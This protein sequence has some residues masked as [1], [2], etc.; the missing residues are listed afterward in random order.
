VS[1]P[2]LEARGVERVFRAGARPLRIVLDGLSLAAGEIALMQAPSGT[3]KS[4][5]MAMLGLV[6]QPDR[7]GTLVLARDAG[8]RLDAAEGWQERAER[9]LGAARASLVGFVMQTGA[10][11]PF[12]TLRDN[13]LEPLRL[14]RRASPG[15]LEALAGALGIDDV[16]DRRPS[17]VSIGQRQRA[18]LARALIGRPALLLADEPTAA[19]DPETAAAVDRLILQAARAQGVAALIASHRP[20]GALAG[21]ARRVGHRIERRADELRSVF[22]A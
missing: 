10:L 1:P 16:L 11:I 20:A 7:I 15:A 17:A 6:T 8:E 3:G 2:V 12:L 18:A 4:T 21:V 13:I 22:F 9:R 14:R 19:L 5:V